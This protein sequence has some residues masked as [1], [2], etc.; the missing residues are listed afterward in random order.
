[1]MLST[2]RSRAIAV[3]VKYCYSHWPNMPSVRCSFTLLLVVGSLDAAMS[4]EAPLIRGARISE[5]E[6]DDLAQRAQQMS[7]HQEAGSMPVVNGCPTCSKTYTESCPL[8]WELD[9][10]D[11]CHAPIG[12]AGYC[13]RG[14]N[15]D[16]WSVESKIVAEMSCSVCW[17]CIDGAASQVAP[18]VE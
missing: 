3:F 5:S 18:S 10:D 7:K 11:L 17:P 13:A 8:T 12:Y 16:G 1:M 6:L 15:F 14:L 9:T 4:W 2:R